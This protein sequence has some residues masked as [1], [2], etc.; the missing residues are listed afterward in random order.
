MFDHLRRYK[1]PILCLVAIALSSCASSPVLP[2][3]VSTLDHPT[4][5]PASTRTPTAIPSPLPTSTATATPKETRNPIPLV[6]CLEINKDN[7]VGGLWDKDNNEVLF[8]MDVNQLLN[9]L[10][11]HVRVNDVRSLDYDPS[12][13]TA[14]KVRAIYTDYSPA[15]SPNQPTLAASWDGKSWQISCVTTI[16]SLNPQQI[17]K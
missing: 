1:F 14:P 7:P 15:N 5:T 11:L 3:V 8:F 9:S 4:A 2:T 17:D 12:F 6:R 10:W 13:S 16:W